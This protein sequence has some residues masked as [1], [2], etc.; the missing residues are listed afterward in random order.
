MFKYTHSSSTETSQVKSILVKVTMNST[1]TLNLLRHKVS[2]SKGGFYQK[3][4]QEGRRESHG[5]YVIKKCLMGLIN[6]ICQKMGPSATQSTE[7]RII[8]PYTN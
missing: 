2:D 8:S 6:P 3:Q 1:L 7:K 5:N 4:V